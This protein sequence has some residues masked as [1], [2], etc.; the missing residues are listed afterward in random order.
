MSKDTKRIKLERINTFFDENR[1]LFGFLFLSYAL[2]A[3]AGIGFAV[4]LSADSA[5]E[6]KSYINGFLELSVTS[7]VQRRDL[8]IESFLSYLKPIFVIWVLGASL[9]GAP[10][11]F[12]FPAMRGFSTLFSIMFFVMAFGGQGIGF[13][14]AG[15]VLTE[16]LLIPVLIF[17]CGSSIRFSVKVCHTGKQ[18]LLRYTALSLAVCALASGLTFLETELLPE[19]FKIIT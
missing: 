17:Y 7:D 9:V 5:I 4:C 2:G 19:A 12:L 16:L 14:L 6:L 8:W 15:I 1:R 10:L 11:I 13:S 3:L 18:S